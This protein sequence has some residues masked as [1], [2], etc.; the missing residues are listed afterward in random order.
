MMRLVLHKLNLYL[1]LIWFH[2]NSSSLLQTLLFL[3][4]SLFW[5]RFERQILLQL[6]WYVK[7]GEFLLRP[8]N[9]LLMKKNM[10]LSRVR[11]TQAKQRQDQ[12]FQLELHGTI[13][14]TSVSSKACVYTCARARVWCVCICMCVF[15]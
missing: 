11:K 1:L 5:L 9:C 7:R 12:L 2:N 4:G 3:F 8:L 13:R 6:C 14:V 15:L 10:V